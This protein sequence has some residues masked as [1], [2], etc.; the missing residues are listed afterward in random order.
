MKQVKAFIRQI[1]QLTRHNYCLILEDPYISQTAQPGQFLHLRT[2]SG[3]APF[4]RRPFSVA[5][6]NPADGTVCV[7]FRRIGT[8]T[9]LLSCMQEGDPLDC[10]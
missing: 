5:G 10:Q 7:I 2:G 9:D 4:L 8:G 3:L 1:R 6:A